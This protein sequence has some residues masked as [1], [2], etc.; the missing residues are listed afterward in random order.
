ML[1]KNTLSANSSKISYITISYEAKDFHS[2]SEIFHI[3][4]LN[5]TTLHLNHFAS[6]YFFCPLDCCLWSESILTV[7]EASKIHLNDM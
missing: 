1:L 5:Q 7:T 6:D 3:K 2:G 4:N